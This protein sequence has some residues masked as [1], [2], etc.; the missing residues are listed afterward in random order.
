[1]SRLR[2]TAL[3]TPAKWLMKRQGD[4]QRRLKLLEKAKGGHFHE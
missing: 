1:M 2:R 3:A 4:M